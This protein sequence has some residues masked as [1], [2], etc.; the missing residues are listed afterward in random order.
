MNIYK[1]PFYMY[2]YKDQASAITT[3]QLT[4]HTDYAYR[5]LIYLAGMKNSLTTIQAITET[6]TISRTHLMKVVNSLVNQ[7]WVSSTRGKHGGIC[8]AVPPNDINLGDVFK[9]MEKTLDPINCD[10]PACHI[11]GVCALKPIL[12]QAQLAFI[13]VLSAHTLADLLNDTTLIRLNEPR[14]R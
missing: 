13:D 12:F 1:D 6:F 9:A 4:K 5:V 8:L 10:S 11:R 14:P 2:I 3:M 7:G